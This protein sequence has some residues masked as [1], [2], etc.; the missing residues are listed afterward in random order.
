MNYK[1]NYNDYLAYVKTLN[2]SKNEGTYYEEHHIIPRSLGGSDEAS[3]KVLLTSR[4][5]YLAHYLLMKIYE[6]NTDGSYRKMVYA[7]MCMNWDKYSTRYKNSRLYARVKEIA[8]KEQKLFLKE[9]TEQKEIWYKKWREGAVHM[10][11]KTSKEYQE[12]ERITKAAVPQLRDKNSPEYKDW[13]EKTQRNKACLKD[14]D[15]EQYKS[16]YR[17]MMEGKHK[18]KKIWIYNEEL[19]KSVTITDEDYPLYESKGW[20]KGRR[21]Y[22]KET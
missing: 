13:Y 7:F 22:N 2:R 6:E 17:K 20:K 14:K 12:W 4:E 11:D 1:Q 3:N 8:C 10:K 5:H 15:S 21:F 18:Y 19:K 9:G 16:W